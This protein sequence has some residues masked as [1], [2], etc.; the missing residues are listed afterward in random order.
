MWRRR[1]AWERKLR[2]QTG[3]AKGRSSAGMAP[4][5]SGGPGFRLTRQRQKDLFVVER[6]GLQGGSWKT[7]H[8]AGVAGVIKKRLQRATGGFLVQPGK[9]G[10]FQFSDG[11][12]L[13]RGGLG[14][15]GQLHSA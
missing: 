11:A 8:M 6:V 10:I 2:R 14:H 7:A 15:Y 4:L 1:L 5:F 3:Q 12:A 13:G 9:H